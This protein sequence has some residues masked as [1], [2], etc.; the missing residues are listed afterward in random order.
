MIE[1]LWTSQSEM[2][3]LWDQMVL[4]LLLVMEMATEAPEVRMEQISQR[5][6]SDAIERVR[7]KP[8][9]VGVKS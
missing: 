3:V 4:P 2:E 9:A 5:S 8:D 6:G 7:A 1:E